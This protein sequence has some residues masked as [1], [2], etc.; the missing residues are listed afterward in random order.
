MVQVYYEE[1]GGHGLRISFFIM[2]SSF[3]QACQQI[4]QTSLKDMFPKSTVEDE[5]NKKRKSTDLGNEGTSK[6]NRV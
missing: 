3:T 4:G 5:K 2:P 6:K 1:E